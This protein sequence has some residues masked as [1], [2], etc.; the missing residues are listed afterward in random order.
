[1]FTGH[2]DYNKASTGEPDWDKFI[3]CCYDADYCTVSDCSFG[4]HEYGVILGYPDDTQDVKNKYDNYPRMTLASNK[5]Y[6]TLTRGPG[7][8]RWGYYHSLNNYVNEFSMAYTVHSGCDIYAENCYYE[9][10]GNVIC[11]WNEITFVGAYAETGSKFVNCKRTT[12]E[13]SALNS[14][15]RPEKNYNYVSIKAD[16]AKT[17]CNNYS[18]C[19]SNNNNWMYLRFSKSG[20]PSAGYY[21]SANEEP[22]IDNY[23]PASFPE[24]ATYR[25]KNV[26]SGLY[27]E[28]ASAEAKNGANVQQWGSD[29]SETHNIWKLYPAGDG[30]YYIISAIGDG[31]TFALDVAGKKTDN[32]TNVDIYQHNSGTNQ[33]FMLT[34]NADGS[35]KIRTRI[36]GEKSAVEIADAS[37]ES[38]A[39]AQQ[40]EINGVNCQDWILESVADTG[41]T[42]DTSVMYTFTNLNSG[43]ALEI[44][45][46]KIEDNANIQQ[47]AINDYDN[48]KWILKAFGSGNYYYICS[49][50]DTNYVLK[51]EGNKNG[52]NID[53]VKYS[54]KDSAMLFRFTKNLDGSY[55]IMTHASKDTALVE[56]ASASLENGANIQQWE[57]NGNTCQKWNVKTESIVT[58]QPTEPT[59][60]IEPTAPT[61]PPKP[62]EP[63]EPSKPVAIKGDIDNDGQLTVLD[64]VALHRYLM[65]QQRFTK[66]QYLI[67]DMNQDSIV[68]IYD[69]VLL[70]K[71]LLAK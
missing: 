47:W 41:V 48:Q 58:I 50:R 33:Q 35:Y 53:I 1:T 51:A 14:T 20:V 57:S 49:A 30:Y 68:N 37:K 23:T 46:G 29:G 15:W 64:L 32:G 4:L 16:E 22:V 67:A 69:L 39:N 5:F 24:G 36:S 3:A 56:V 45:D 59:K 38:G 12:I 17:Y 26:N 61:E 8:M 27:L 11:D 7:L 19:Q 55:S 65:L 40:W 71:A 60:P 66:E 10:G 31:A 54:N 9:N 44:A 2:A 25:F 34:Q 63:T 52:S 21:E 70:K 43:L 13:G 42:M 6:Q 62:T 28:V 18:G